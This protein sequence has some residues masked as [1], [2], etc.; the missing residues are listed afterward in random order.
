[1]H[2]SHMPCLCADSTPGCV[3]AAHL[4][5]SHAHPHPWRVLRQ[6]HMPLLS[7]WDPAA[8]KAQLLEGCG[9]GSHPPQCA[10]HLAPAAVN[11]QV[12]LVR[13]FAATG[14][15]HKGMPASRACW[16]LVEQPAV[17]GLDYNQPCSILRRV[18]L[19]AD[20]SQHQHGRKRLRLAAGWCLQ[21]VTA[22]QGAQAEVAA[23]MYGYKAR[24]QLSAW[25]C[26]K[27][28]NTAA[29]H[30]STRQ[31]AGAAR[32]KAPY[33]TR[34]VIGCATPLLSTTFNCSRCAPGRHS[35]QPRSSPQ[36]SERGILPADD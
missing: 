7:V 25:R 4:S 14:A 27:V 13:P 23:C 34:V 8:G 11:L 19:P 5:Q 3:A 29:R 31:K 26:L 10:M 17:A 36:R 30:R 22:L 2:N 35:T 12:Q 16:G 20:T 1:M 21:V 24:F 6:P 28:T 15:G 18:C 33:P 32:G 9:A